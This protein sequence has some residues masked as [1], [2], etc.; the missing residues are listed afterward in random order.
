VERIDKA[1]KPFQLQS[2]N[3]GTSS[4][5]SQLKNSINLIPTT[6]MPPNKEPSEGDIVFN[7][8]SVA[9]AKNQRLIASWLPPR[10]AQE[11]SSSKTD[12]ELAREE[13]E[14][15]APV[16]ELSVLGLWTFWPMLIELQSGC[17]CNSPYRFQGW[18]AAAARL[19][20]TG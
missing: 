12:E 11:L 5:S 19:V 17:R 9:L 4:T 18:T 6:I 7:R 2:R 3:L 16:P 10:T 13:Q 8:A 20:C 14:M 15:F 1:E